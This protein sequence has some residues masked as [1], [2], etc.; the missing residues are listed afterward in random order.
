MGNLIYSIK[1]GDWN[2][3]RTAIQ[4]LASIRLGTDTSPVLGGIT[5]EGTATVSVLVATSATINSLAAVSGI[6][7][8]RDIGADGAQLDVL[9]GELGPWLDD[10]V[11]EDGGRMTTTQ[12]ATFAQLVL[13]PRASALSAV[14]G[15]MFYDSDDNNVYICTEGA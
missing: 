12:I 7:D 5:I 14:E 8:S 11:L 2:S 3:V 10:V 13:T 4:K 6:I 9:Y 15:A 1:E